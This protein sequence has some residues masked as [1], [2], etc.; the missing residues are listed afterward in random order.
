MVDGVG[1]KSGV[2]QSIAHAR[3][4]ALA[5]FQGSHH[6]MGVVG[7][8]EAHDFRVDFRAAGERV[9]QRFQHEHAGAFAHDEAAAAGRRRDGKPF[10]GSS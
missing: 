7:S 10:S 5:G 8:A 2:G 4:H 1:R 3:G 9:L 6:V